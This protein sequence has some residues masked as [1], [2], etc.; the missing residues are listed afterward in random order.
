MKKTLSREVAVCMFLWLGFLSY[1]INNQEM[2]ETLI[3]PIST[4]GLFAFGFKQ[5][6]V[7][8]SLRG[9]TSKSTDRRGP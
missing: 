2:V 7:G 9:R 8:D 1:D 6:V 3:W 4:F 5:P